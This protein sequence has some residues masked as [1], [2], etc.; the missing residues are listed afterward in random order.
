MSRQIQLFE[1]GERNVSDGST[2][3]PGFWGTSW[4]ALRAL[5]GEELDKAQQIA[6]EVSHLAVIP[7]QRGIAENFTFQFEGR[8]FQIKGIED[9]DEM[10]V[11]LVLYAFEV[12]QNAGQQS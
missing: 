7:Y 10:H 8:S 9:I 12:G 3:A 5:Q 2:G 4:A 6:Q 1:P 11:Q